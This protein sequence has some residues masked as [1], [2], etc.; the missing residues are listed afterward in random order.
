METSREDLA[1]TDT[2]AGA[3]DAGALIKEWRPSSRRTEQIAA[4]LAAQIAGGQLHRWD[5]LPPLAV[6]ADEYGVTGRT[7]TSVKR[8]LAVHGF[9]ALENG[10]YY[11]A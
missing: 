4:E 10:R 5:E 7:V 3:E 11:V 2:T 8:L 6:L 1:V 9:L